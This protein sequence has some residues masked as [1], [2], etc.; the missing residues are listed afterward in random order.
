MKKDKRRPKNNVSKKRFAKN[1]KRKKLRQKGRKL[2]QEL[3][4]QKNAADAKFAKNMWKGTTPLGKPFFDI[5]YWTKKNPY[6]KDGVSPQTSKEMMR[7]FLESVGG[8]DPST[9]SQ[10]VMNA[11]ST[12]SLW[13]AWKNLLGKRDEVDVVDTPEEPF[14]WFAELEPLITN[15]K[16]WW[17]LMIGV[18]TYNASF[19]TEECLFR[20]DRMK[21]PFTDRTKWMEYLDVMSGEHLKKRGHF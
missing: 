11:K 8:D 4:L 18:W 7:H 14:R 17:V 13:Y 6:Y 3:I 21:V 15:D 12:A 5:N 10:N 16:M 1:L 20:Y 19:F 9:Y 2:G